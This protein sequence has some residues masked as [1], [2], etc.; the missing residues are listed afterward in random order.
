MIT[1]TS[2]VLPHRTKLDGEEKAHADRDIPE[3]VLTKPPPPR[4]KTNF[5]GRP[6]GSLPLCQGAGAMVAAYEDENQ[7]DWVLLA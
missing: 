5:R 6:S 1:N 4:S 3:D 2:V 7:M